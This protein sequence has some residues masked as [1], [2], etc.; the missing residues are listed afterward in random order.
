MI[1]DN[2]NSVYTQ[3]F[4][5]QKTLTCSDVGRE[6]LPEDWSSKET[7]A[8]RYVHNNDLYVLKGMKTEADI[9]LNLLVWLPLLRGLK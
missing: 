3:Y 5:F 9:V 1:K 6:T 2:L 7:Y 8:L 4:I